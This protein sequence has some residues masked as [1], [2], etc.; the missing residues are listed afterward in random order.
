MSGDS[1][2]LHHRL[3]VITKAE[4]S[5]LPVAGLALFVSLGSAFRPVLL[6]EGRRGISLCMG[7]SAMIKNVSD[8]HSNPYGHLLHGSAAEGCRNPL[9]ATERKLRQD[10]QT[11][12]KR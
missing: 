8:A 12:L 11:S 6:P 3:S 5:V 9:Q 10:Q 7:V 2:A 1:S 4:H